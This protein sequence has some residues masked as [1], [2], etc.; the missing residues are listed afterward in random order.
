VQYIAVA[1]MTTASGTASQDGPAMSAFSRWHWP[2]P[3]QP[4]PGQLGWNLT[5]MHNGKR[6]LG[7]SLERNWTS[8]EDPMAHCTGR[9]QATLPRNHPGVSG[10]PRRGTLGTPIGYCVSA[11]PGVALLLSC[12]AVQSCVY[13]PVRHE[14]GRYLCPGSGAVPQPSLAEVNTPCLPSQPVVLP[15]CDVACR[16][17]N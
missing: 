15:E 14:P 5:A 3:M 17:R 16:R 13:S 2:A 4:P 11:R 10:K 9:K 7:S 1:I 12:R 8:Q 6:L